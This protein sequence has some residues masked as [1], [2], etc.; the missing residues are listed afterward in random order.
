MPKFANQGVTDTEIVILE[1][2]QFDTGRATIKPVSSA[3]LDKV[4]KVLKDHP[5][6]LLVEVQGHTDN[7]GGKIYNATL[8]SPAPRP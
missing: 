6:L 8:S 5:E 7:R 2:V 3:L 4:A 1:Q